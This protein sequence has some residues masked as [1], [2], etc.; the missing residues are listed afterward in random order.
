MGRQNS[1]I[2]YPKFP[3][4]YELV[5]QDKLVMWVAEEEGEMSAVLPSVYS[6]ALVMQP[7]YRHYV[8]VVVD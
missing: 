3:R 8:V 5:D 7:L 4:L 1:S 2:D 6:L